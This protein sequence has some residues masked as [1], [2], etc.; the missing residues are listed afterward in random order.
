MRK[1]PNNYRGTNKFL[2]HQIARALPE[3]VDAGWFERTNA[4]GTSAGLSQLTLAPPIFLIAN[5]EACLCEELYVDKVLAFK[6]P[7]AEEDPF[8][9]L[10]DDRDWDWVTAA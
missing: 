2:W 4:K 6:K 7:A 8:L 1:S 5:E 9:V 10:D 3:R